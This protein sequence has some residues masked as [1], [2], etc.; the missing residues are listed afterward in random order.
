MVPRSWDFQE[1][2]RVSTGS[3]T[4]RNYA[5]TAPWGCHSEEPT[6]SHHRWPLMLGTGFQN[7]HHR[8][9]QTAQLYLQPHESRHCSSGILPHWV[10]SLYPGYKG[11]R[12]RG[13]QPFL[14][15]RIWGISQIWN[16][17]SK[18]AGGH[19]RAYSRWE[20]RGRTQNCF[21]GFSLSD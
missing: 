18:D 14:L 5:G 21:Q 9:L 10:R 7:L 6:V 2:Q 17:W 15:L 3:H 19:Q 13:I 11:D 8:L 12:E 20:R 16:G 1:V 4:A